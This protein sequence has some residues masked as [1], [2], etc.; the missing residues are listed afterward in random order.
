M[1]RAHSQLR[2]LLIEDSEEDVADLLHLFETTLTGVTRNQPDRTNNGWDIRIA[3]ALEASE[4][5]S[6]SHPHLIELRK[7][8]AGEF[9]TPATLNESNKQW[10]ATQ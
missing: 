9:L 7:V 3:L 2:V 6:A 4:N 8:L 5:G 1:E 10:H